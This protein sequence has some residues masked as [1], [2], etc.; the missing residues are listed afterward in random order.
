MQ[1]LGKML[2][3][4]AAEPR[5][6]LPKPPTLAELLAAAD[7]IDALVRD[8]AA[9]GPV[10]SRVLRVTQVVRQTLPRLDQLGSGSPQAFSVMATV[11]DYLPEAIEGYLRLPREWANS[12]PVDAG[13]S[14]LMVLID[15]LDLLAG[16]MDRV[17][18]AACREDAAALVAHGQFLQE[19]FGSPGGGGLSLP[20]GDE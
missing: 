19:K 17:F 1:I 4:T 13:R 12:R 5:L 3:R 10:S 9:P 11:T 14:S 18:D 20:E 7:R 15:Q 8:S 16:T 2:G 6:E